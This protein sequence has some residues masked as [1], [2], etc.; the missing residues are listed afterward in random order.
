MPGQPTHIYSDFV[1]DEPL[2]ESKYALKPETRPP[3]ASWNFS[4][5]SLSTAVKGKRLD[6]INN[7][8]LLAPFRK[9]LHRI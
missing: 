8:N 5:P 1:K 4:L 9:A 2:N 3:A 7:L 6:T